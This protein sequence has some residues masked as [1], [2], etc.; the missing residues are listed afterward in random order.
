LPT[1]RPIVSFDGQQTA[2]SPHAQLANSIRT[3][4]MASVIRGWRCSEMG[5]D[6]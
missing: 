1:F 3:D 6:E 4:L 5:K 2:L